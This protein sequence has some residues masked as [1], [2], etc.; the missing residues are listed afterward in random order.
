MSTVMFRANLVR[1]SRPFYNEAHLYADTEACYKVLQVSD[2]GFVHQV[3]TFSRVHPEQLS[4]FAAS[5]DTLPLARVAVT[6]DFGR[7]FLE[8]G[9]YERQVNRTVDR[10]Y[11]ILGGHLLKGK[12]A[13][14]WAY[15]QKALSELG[16]PFSWPRVVKEACAVVGRGFARPFEAVGRKARMILTRPRRTA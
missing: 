8:P 6:K 1:A 7:S 16:V 3:L 9:E 13:A 4:S 15:H 5:H 12:R 10:Y 2:F 11:A 14:F